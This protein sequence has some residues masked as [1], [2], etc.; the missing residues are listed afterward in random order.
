MPIWLRKFTWNKIIAHHNEEVER[1]K[2]ENNSDSN[3]DL[4]KP[5]KGN[6]PKKTISPPSYVTSSSRKK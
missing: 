1:V 4:S 5:Y 6:I 2:E 3:I